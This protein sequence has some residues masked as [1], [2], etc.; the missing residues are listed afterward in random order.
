MTKRYRMMVAGLL[1]CLALNVPASAQDIV[2]ITVLN[3]SSPM[4]SSSDLIERFFETS[5][6]LEPLLV[7]G[8]SVSFTHRLAF[9]NTLAAG[10]GLPQVNKRN[11]VYQLTFTVEDP[12]EVGYQVDVSSLMR[13][14]SSI[15]QTEGAQAAN[16][17]GLMLGVTYGV[18]TTDPAAFA[19]LSG[20][21]G[22]STTGVSVTGEGTATELQESLATAPLGAGS[23]VGTRTFSLFFTSTP[24][25]TT[26]VVFQNYTVGSGFVNYGLGS[27]VGN[28]G[29]SPDDLGHFVTV[30]VA[31]DGDVV[32]TATDTWSGVKALFR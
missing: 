10:G 17:T 3:S 14:V 9:L 18:D 26:N 22:Q 4:P 2:G 7:D 25:P 19:T 12:D 1:A 16:A 8:S 29:A 20:I 15:T 28:S 23:Y 6:T 11:V 30:H 27:D 31:F 32:A 21:Y 13:G 5:S 24:T